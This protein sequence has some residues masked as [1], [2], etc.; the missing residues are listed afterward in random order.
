M[1]I[2]PM[3]GRNAR[4]LLGLNGE[5]RKGGDLVGHRTDWE[6]KPNN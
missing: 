5:E 3:T 6:D 4:C 1:R 2:S